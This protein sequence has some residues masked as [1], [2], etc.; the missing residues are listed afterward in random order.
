MGDSPTP[1]SLSHP[2]VQKEDDRFRKAEQLGDGNLPCKNLVDALALP[3]TIGT[4]I[5]ASALFTVIT[6]G[7]PFQDLSPEGCEYRGYLIQKLAMSG[8]MFA[9]ATAN[10]LCLQ[11]LYSSPSFCKI[12]YKKLNQNLEIRTEFEPWPSWDFMRYVVSYV[13]VA[14]AFGSVGLHMLGTMLIFQL[15]PYH[16]KPYVTQLILGMG[17]FVYACIW[18]FSVILERPPRL[19]GGDSSQHASSVTRSRYCSCNQGRA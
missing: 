1:A 8:F 17:C 4:A 6:A 19:R 2:E 11:V 5:A 13:A 14:S 3:G 9:L 16:G 18:G 15:S 10:A 12:L 7:P